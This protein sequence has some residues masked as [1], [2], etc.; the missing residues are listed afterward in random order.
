MPRHIMAR[1]QKV[2]YSL[3]HFS[4]LG[5]LCADFPALERGIAEGKD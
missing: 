2:E 1:Q 4:W 3:D 5:T